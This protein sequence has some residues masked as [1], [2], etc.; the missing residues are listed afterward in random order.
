MGN[1]VCC[2][3]VYLWVC[4]AKALGVLDD[5]EGH[6]GAE[7]VGHRCTSMLQGGRGAYGGPTLA[8]VP[9]ERAFS[10]AGA[11]RDWGIAVATPRPGD[12]A[13]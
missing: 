2:E 3:S 1:H 7:G 11:E 12:P 6:R 9:G 13:R 4:H 10:V 8:G 5:H